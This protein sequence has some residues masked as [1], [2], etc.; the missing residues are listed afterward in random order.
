MYDKVDRNREQTECKDEAGGCWKG[1]L[2][3]DE[4]PPQTAFLKDLDLVQWANLE[5]Q[6]SFVK[7]RNI[8]VF[9]FR[10]K[11]LAGMLGMD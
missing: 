11:R 3:S 8:T 1:S 4:K 7:E 2:S 10:T 6:K 9:I 5:P